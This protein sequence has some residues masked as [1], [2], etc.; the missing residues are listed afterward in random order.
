M[1]A[2]SLIPIHTRIEKHEKK[3]IRVLI[4]ET[5]GT[6]FFPYAIFAAMIT[7]FLFADNAYRSPFLTELGYPLTYI[8]LVMGGSRI[9]WWAVGRS[10]KYIER[11]ISFQ[12]LILI[13]L[14]LFPLY[15]ITA[16]YISNPW[17][18]GIVFSLVVGWFWGRNEIYTDYLIDHI[19]D[20]RYRATVLSMKSQ[21]ENVVQIVISFGIAGVMGIS[22]QLGFQILGYLMFAILACIYY[23]GIRKIPV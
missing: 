20:S 2:F 9:V 8:G 16:G 13:E 23:F 12:R 15:Y 14:C 18:L 17:L 19:S 22:Y 21:I 3:S 5:K 10:I 11:Y 4:Q 1:V 6:G 7:G